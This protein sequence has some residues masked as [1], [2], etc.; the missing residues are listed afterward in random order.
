[1]MYVVY[2]GLSKFISVSTLPH[3]GNGFTIIHSS[4]VFI[5]GSIFSMILYST[6][7]DSLLPPIHMVPCPSKSPTI[8]YTFLN[9]K[10]CCGIWLYINNLPWTITFIFCCGV[11]CLAVVSMIID[12][13]TGDA[14]DVVSGGS[15]FFLLLFPLLPM[16]IP[17]PLFL[18]Y[19][20][21][22][23]R[24]LLLLLL[25]YLLLFIIQYPFFYFYSSSSSPPLIFFLLLQYLSS[26]PSFTSSA[27]VGVVIST[28]ANDYI[29]ID[30]T[31]SVS[32]AAVVFLFLLLL[33]ISK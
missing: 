19:Y 7:V 26:H 1:M 4:K 18:P 5:G 15:F 14:G 33:A 30:S 13:A 9:K 25:F 32:A 31:I 17:T 2:I 29:S 28:T 12:S 23:R 6:C 10:T 3:K 20:F 27:L 16:L 24:L 21:P 11:W 8:L 22:W